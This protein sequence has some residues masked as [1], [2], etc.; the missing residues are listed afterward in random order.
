MSRLGACPVVVPWDTWTGKMP[1]LLE[2]FLKTDSETKQWSLVL[3]SSKPK[4]I[5]GSTESFLS[6]EARALPKIEDF[7]RNACSIK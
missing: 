7:Y 2:W 1:V 4:T 5:T 6:F 3:H